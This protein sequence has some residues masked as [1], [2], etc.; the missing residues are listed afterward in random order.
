MT[1][2]TRPYM[3]L[4][5]PLFLTNLIDLERS[6]KVELQWSHIFEFFSRECRIL[7]KHLEA[8]LI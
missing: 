6:Y 3:S 7:L 5:E 1:S 4:S 2:G 8:K